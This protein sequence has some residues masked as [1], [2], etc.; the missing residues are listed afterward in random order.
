MTLI[1]GLCVACSTDTETNTGNKD[2]LIHLSAVI[3]GAISTRAHSSTS[4][5]KA[6]RVRFTNNGSSNLT[7]ERSVA[8]NGTFD[9]LHW[10]DI[11]TS[12]VDVREKKANVMALSDPRTTGAIASVPV[13]GEFDWSVETVQTSKI[14]LQD[15]L[16][17]DYI[18][19]QEKTSAPV[20]LCFHHAMT[21]ITVNLIMGDGFTAENF[22]NPIVILNGQ[23]TKAN[24]K[25]KLATGSSSS[26][27]VTGSIA[28][29]ITM[30]KLVTANTYTSN[31]T[32]T[33]Y[34]AS[35]EAIVAPGKTLTAPDAQLAT[36]TVGGN[37]YHMNLSL[38]NSAWGTALQHGT[39]YVVAVRLS[40]THI[41]ASAVVADWENGG[42][43]DV[44]DDA[45]TFN[46][47]I[48][49]NEGI[50]ASLQSGGFDIY[51]KES[52]A[53]AYG[54]A[55]M[56]YSYSNN[57]WTAS[58]RIYWKD[59]S[60]SYH[61]RAVSPSSATE[62]NDLI[63]V[64]SGNTDYLY[65][66]T[67][68]FTWGTVPVPQ[69]GAVPPRSGAVN[70][71]F[72]HVMSKITVHLSSVAINSGG[73]DLTGARIV[74]KQ[75]RSSSKMALSD[76]SMADYATASSGFS[77]TMNGNDCMFYA[78]PQNLGNATID[79]TDDLYFEIT[80]AGNIYKVYLKNVT[81][82]GVVTTIQNWAA[83][84]QYSYTF[85]LY[86]STVNFSAKVLDWE[87]GGTTDGD[88]QL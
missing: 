88:V 37:T 86:K 23:N 58:P 7:A 45:V 40:K 74:L 52:T 11:S 49:G 73:V 80:V 28:A 22:T 81:S 77:A 18:S 19:L 44:A 63:S 30:D 38:L 6:Y 31:G 56:T 43:V 68:A 66:T 61:F 87:D 76:G 4:L 2:E 62:S 78:I 69:G 39:H 14:A 65:G 13:N 48:N 47:D 82:N 24:V 54:A 72:T 20:E 42:S 32:A 12:S 26:G 41:N 34:A 33:S 70:L 84:K 79:T 59:S 53:S 17:S 10:D 16:I 1:S 51:S 60:T 55:S 15:L 67:S 85:K 25:L 64:S 36:I 5:Q 46:N 9:A 71:G 3:D 27:A 83:G 29:D 8:V 35:Y 50:A 21:K 75:A 57:E